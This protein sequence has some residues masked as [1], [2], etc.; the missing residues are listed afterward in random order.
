M[1]NTDIVSA[2]DNLDA[3]IIENDVYSPEFCKN[4][5]KV[6]SAIKSELGKIEKS[7]IKIA[8]SLHWVRVSNA[9]MVFGYDNIADY[10]VNELGIKKSL[11]YN[12][13]G[14]AE[15]FGLRDDSDNVVSID[16]KY[17]DYSVSKLS[18]MAS[19]TDDELEKV[20]P[21]MTVKD[22]KKI[23]KDSV[24]VDSSSDDVSPPDDDSPSGASTSVDSSIHIFK[25]FECHNSFDI[26]K[27][28]SDAFQVKFG[29][30]IDNALDTLNIDD[31]DNCTFKIIVERDI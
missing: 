4:A 31:F 1:D 23:A 2:S 26:Q 24:V 27:V 22:I 20:N 12:L 8:V 10:A 29:D 6:N 17:K 25:F 9:F 18:A 7:F 11:C 16:D 28:L 5:K 14:I 15:R 3:E 13:I 30:M 19:L 21:D